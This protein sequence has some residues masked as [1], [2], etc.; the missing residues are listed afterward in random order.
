[1]KIEEK[2]KDCNGCGQPIGNSDHLIVSNG[3]IAKSG[4]CKGC[5]GNKFSGKLGTCVQCIL[6][7][8]FGAI[9]GWLAYLI[10][11]FLDHEKNIKYSALVV[12]AFFTILLI[13][14]GIAYF[15][16]RSSKKK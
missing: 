2:N 13:A 9:F 6:T 3:N 7:A 1:M 4:G 10:L 15:I 16:K 5:S 8:S 14:H 12:A 11:F